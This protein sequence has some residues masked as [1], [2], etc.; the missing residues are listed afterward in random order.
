MEYK[1]PKVKCELCGFEMSQRLNGSHLARKHSI[2]I[3]EYLNLYPNAATGSYITNTF[4]CLI[5]NENVSSCSATKR[6][7]ILSHGLTID[8]Y[9]LNFLKKYCE[10]GCGE[11]T[12]YSISRNCY[13]RYVAGHNVVWNKGLKKSDGHNL[14][15]GGWNK[16][17]TMEVDSRIISTSLAVKAAWAS[18]SYVNMTSKYQ[19]TSMKKYGVTNYSLTYEFKQRAISSSLERYGVEYPMQS[20]EIYSKSKKGRYKFKQYYWPSGNVSE[21]QGYEPYALDILLESY[22]ESELIVD[23]DKMPEIW[24]YLEDGIKRHRYFPDIWISSLNKFIEVKSTFTWNLDKNSLYFKSKSIKE[25]G[26]QFEIWI[27]EN[28]KIKQI[29]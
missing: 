5:C 16:G 11:L 27:I 21:V 14:A 2:S 18:G 9:N 10:C 26:Y 4:T 20:S 19:E 3:E 28:K 17:L 12:E 13:N 29:L 15:G 23:K 22:N 8:E 25:S 24:Y 7:H 1:R 6:K